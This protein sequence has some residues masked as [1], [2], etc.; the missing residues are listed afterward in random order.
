MR[1][2]ALD[3]QGVPLLVQRVYIQSNYSVSFTLRCGSNVEM[4]LADVC[5]M[6]GW[7]FKDFR[8]AVN[9]VPHEMCQIL[10][11]IVLSRWDERKAT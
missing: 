2:L 9:K 3:N 5:G 8:N 6:L 11:K 1:R 7:S 10:E 4:E